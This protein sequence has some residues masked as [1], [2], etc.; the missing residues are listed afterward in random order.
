MGQGMTFESQNF[1]FLI[2]EFSFNNPSIITKL[3]QEDLKVRQ[4][5]SMGD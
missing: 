5:R 3:F 4:H 2:S 1:Y